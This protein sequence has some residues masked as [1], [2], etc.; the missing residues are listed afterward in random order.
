M[1]NNYTIT[2]ILLS[3]ALAQM[4]KHL[5]AWKDFVLFHCLCVDMGVGGNYNGDGS[6]HYNEDNQELNSH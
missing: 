3:L 4:F 6:V 1:I 2:S 5:T